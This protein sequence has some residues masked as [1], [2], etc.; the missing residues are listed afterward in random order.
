MKSYFKH[1]VVIACLLPLM[2]FNIKHS[3]DWGDDFAQYLLEARNILEH[4]PIGQTGFVENPNF[5]LGPNCYPPGFPLILALTSPFTH[6]GMAGLNVL[7]SFFLVL[8]GYFSFL[9]LNKWFWFAPSL[10]LSL[11]IAYNPLCLHLKTEVLSDYPF[12]AV[13]LLFFVLYLN[14]EKNKLN[15][16]T[17]GVLIGMAI[18]IRYVGWILLL[19]VITEIAF[20][21]CIRFYRRKKVDKIYLRDH[22]YLFGSFILTHLLLYL[23]FPQRIVYYDNPQALPFFQRISYNA[24]YNYAQLKYFFSC[25][26]E[27]FLNYIISYG[28]VFFALIGMLLFIFKP[29]PLK[30]TVLLFFFLGYILSILIHQYSDTGLRLVMPVITIVLFFATYAL[31]IILGFIP[32][33]EYIAFSFGLIVLFCYKDNSKRILNSDNEFPGPYTAEAA[34][35]FSFIRK[36]TPEQ[37]SLLF[38][39]PRA[40][41]Y[42]TSRRTMINTEWMKKAFIASELEKLHPDYVMICN[43]ITDD[44]TKLFFAAPLPGWKLE[45]ASQN[46]KLYK[47]L[48]NSHL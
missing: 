32:Y 3:H 8:V 45:Y 31:L 46:Y 39:K 28:F 47:K 35:A 48:L 2:F 13:L 6:F 12:T 36:N 41:T 24:N 9:L 18:S 23:F 26:D 22:A 20:K 7:I 44:S 25:F 40:L 16:I 34:E 27:G 19:A 43:E 29:D 37:A 33:K 15:F 17:C 14:D 10:V 1:I 4:K 38:S 42:F 21:L 5:V 30:P 11:I